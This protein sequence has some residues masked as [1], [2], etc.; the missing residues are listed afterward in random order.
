MVIWPL[1]SAP[2][3]ADS[4]RV[5]PCGGRAVAVQASEDGS[6]W[7]LFEQPGL[8]QV[9]RVESPTE[10]RALCDALIQARKQDELLEFWGES[11]SEVSC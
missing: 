9:W 11:P 2:Q 4:V 6:C 5:C 8:C 3:L 10:A 1:V 7:V